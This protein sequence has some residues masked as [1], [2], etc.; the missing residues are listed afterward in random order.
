MTYLTIHEFN[1]PMAGSGIKEFMNKK[2]LDRFYSEA[3]SL[4]AKVR[5]DKVEAMPLST[6]LSRYGFEQIDLFSLD[7]EGGELSVLQSIDFGKLSI[8]ALMIESDKVPVDSLDALL[9]K[10]NYHFRQELQLKRN[11]VDRIYVAG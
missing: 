2:T 1:G 5:E 6:I 4:G 9:K 3:K 10:N 11:P 8:G 7:V